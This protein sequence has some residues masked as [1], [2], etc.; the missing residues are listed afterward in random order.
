MP[1]SNNVSQSREKGY[2]ELNDHSIYWERYGSED[3][4]TVVLLHHGL[5]SIRSW[6][7]QIPDLVNGGYNV[8]AFDRWGYGRSDSRDSFETS[9]LHHDAEETVQ[10]MKGLDIERASLVGHS[11]GGSISLIIAAR[12]PEIVLNLIVIAAHVYIEPK[13]SGG[14]ELIQMAAQQPPLEIVLKREHGAKAQSL[15]QAWLNCWAQHGPLT[16]DLKSEL[17]GINCPTLVIQGEEDEH[18]TPQHA[19]DIAKW[20]KNSKLWLIPGVGHMPPQ[21]FAPEFNRR[22]ID[23]LRERN[24]QPSSLKVEENNESEHV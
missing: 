16:L 20:V 2:T 11:D 4:E 14:L 22:I 7:R 8:F 15:V 23:F 5:G 10:L 1:T 21:E 6:K 3:G 17:G 18:A 19:K 24:A 13:M 9:F 12:H